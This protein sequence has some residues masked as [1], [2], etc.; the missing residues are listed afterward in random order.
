L[1]RPGGCRTTSWRSFPSRDILC[2]LAT[3][4]M[5][6]ELVLLTSYFNLAG[7]RRQDAADTFRVEPSLASG[8]SPDGQAALYVVTE[9]STGGHMGPRARRRAADVV[10]WEY[11]S[12]GEDPPAVRLKRALRAA[13]EA[14][15][16]E[17]DGHV[18]VGLSAMAVERDTVYLCQVPP[19][20]VYVLHDGGLHSISANVGGAS[21]FT[22]ALGSSGGPDVS[23]FRDQ[24]GQEDV[25]VL[26]SS[27]F[28]R[29]VDPEDLRE[30][31]AAETADDIAECLLD[32]A[33][34]NDVQDATGIVIEAG[35][36][37]ELETQLAE[38]E[39]PRF[40]EQVDTAV[41]ALADVGRML[42]SELRPVD[43]RDGRRRAAQAANLEGAA[44]PWEADAA[45][46]DSPGTDMERGTGPPQHPDVS[47]GGAPAAV[48]A[49]EPE[50]GQSAPLDVEP[51]YSERGGLA[52]RHRT[53]QRTDEVPI[54]SGEGRPE[55]PAVD[56][57]AAAERAARSEPATARPPKR[58]AEPV[59]ELDQV[60]SRIQSAPD[61]G[62]V[63][64]PVQ[65][66]PDTSTE[67]ERIYA[68]SKDIQ[69][70]NKRPRRFGGVSDTGPPVIRP[71]L[72]DV[73]LSRPAGRPGPPAVIWFGIAAVFVLA[74]VS[75]ILFLQ[76]RHTPR[77]NPY[78]H[79][80]QRDIA[81]AKR[82]LDPGQ[83]DFYLNKA[84]TEITLA[85][86]NGT[87]PSKIRSMRNQLQAARDLLHKVTREY[88][89]LL[90][91][92]FG[93]FP[94]AQPTEIAAAPGL[95][96][97]LDSKRKGVFSITPNATSNPSLIVTAGDQINGFTVGTPTQ[98]AVDGSTALVLDDRNVL[99]RDS[100]GT[101]T[102]T[103]LTQ[104]A[105]KV[106]FAWMA[107]ADPDVY[108][109]DTSN[110]QLWRYPQA[111]S[112]FNPTPQGFFTSNVP[113]VG[114]SISFAFDR[115]YV[116]LLK[117][118][119]TVLK[120]DILQANPQKWVTDTRSL[121]TPLQNP[122]ALYPDP[123]SNFV[124]IAD[125][126]NSRIVQ[127]DKSGGY[128]RSYVSGN[129]NMDLSQIKSL[130]VAASGKTTYAYVL[131]GSKVFDF[132]VAR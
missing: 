35:S 73:D 43:Q 1:G 29:S 20:Q 70:V 63:I 3:L 108:L 31:F 4:P 87:L 98:I 10:A 5:D 72:G 61:L 54:V 18:A 58:D 112:F 44:P 55:Y 49:L 52:D 51:P 127:F 28:R 26:C 33:R 36:A 47:P 65:A 2:P 62:D 100:A 126:A 89:P 56:V 7:G 121:R 99:V 97:V 119:G 86:Q 45:W 104:P 124:W 82:Q 17:F 14:V 25:V 68:T 94:G 91:S 67:P 111:V 132:P 90:L 78:P 102:A 12:H 115:T 80:V 40:M 123:N 120:F 92:D 32:L 23:V 96:F 39:V 110:S 113:S 11:S 122:V 116:Y 105:P 84:S 81:R 85:K 74:G 41:Q 19:A 13:H 131:C 93:R 109:L 60:N 53:D 125:P 22:S 66:F 21:P 79:F 15:L 71:T 37:R 42:L 9:S 48:P 118:D 129:S 27:W 130:T 38:D 8:T 128:V 34:Q 59:S 24:I 106:T 117:R 77:A 107:V 16:R 103:A 64:P 50:V 83:Q 114:Q 76:H 46:R 75:L 6:D 30:C 101:K 57:R 69:K 95:I 88:S